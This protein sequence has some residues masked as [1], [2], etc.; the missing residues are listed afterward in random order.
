MAQGELLTEVRLSM[1][2][3]RISGTVLPRL[4]IVGRMPLEQALSRRRV[5]GVV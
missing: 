1:K 4:E 5:V 2:V 3:K